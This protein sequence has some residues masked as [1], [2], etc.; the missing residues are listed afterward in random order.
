MRLGESKR[1]LVRTIRMMPRR[2]LITFVLSLAILPALGLAPDAP[3]TVDD[4]AIDLRAH[5]PAEWLETRPMPRARFKKIEGKR[6]PKLNV[7]DW[8]NSN[9]LTL[10][11]LEGRVV[12]LVFWG[13]KCPTCADLA[14]ELNALHE[15]YG[16]DGL[17][18]L[19]VCMSYSEDDYAS[20]VRRKEIAYPVCL[21]NFGQTSMAYKADGTPDV[22]LIDTD[23]TLLVAD[24]KEEYLTRAV[25]S[26]LDIDDEDADSDESRESADTPR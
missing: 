6:A 21:D 10:K 16:E 13:S 20:E 9:A 14:E 5:I 3:V 18:I 11:K 23:G 4:D 2:R 26:L 24:L 22:Y 1:D 15:L 19:G 25:T 8:K 7:K 17:T 12:A